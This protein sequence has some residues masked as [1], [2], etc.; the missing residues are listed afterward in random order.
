[1]KVGSDTTTAPKWL[2]EVVGIGA[3]TAV[4]RFRHS[5]REQ[6]DRVHGAIV[7]ATSRLAPYP[8]GC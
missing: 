6:A 5:A 8:T 4:V 3:V 1:V 7:A 2:E